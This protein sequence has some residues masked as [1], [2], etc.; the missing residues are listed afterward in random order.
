[1]PRDALNKSLKPIFHR[2]GAKSAKVF[3]DRTDAF[4]CVLR[5]FAVNIHLIRVSI[6]KLRALLVVMPANAGIQE[7]H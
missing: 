2:K 3:L 5:V 4:L 7:A 1:M 6:V